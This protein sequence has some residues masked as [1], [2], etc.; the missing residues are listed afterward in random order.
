[1]LDATKDDMMLA[2]LP[3]FHSFGCTVTLWFPLIDGV[4][5]VTY[6]N[7]L[8]AGEMRRADRSLSG[9]GDAGSADFFAR[10]FAQRRTGTIRSVRLRSRARRNCRATLAERFEERLGQPVFEGYGLTETSPVVS[11]NL[12]DPPPPD[13]AD[14]VQP[15]QSP[16]LGR[17]TG[18][19]IGGRNSRPGNRRKTLAARYRHALVA[20]PEHFRGLSE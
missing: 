10:L 6:P 8:E 3:F 18:A 12:P 13:W 20:R 11:V 15:S 14:T 4:R 9:D 7:P 2:S 1:M 19:G 16:R 5:I 17:Q